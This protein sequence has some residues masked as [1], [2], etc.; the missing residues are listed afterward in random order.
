MGIE[1]QVR[2][3][4]REE[5]ERVP[6]WA[7]D[8]ATIRR[9][10]R[11]QSHRRAAVGGV[12]AVAA[13]AAVTTQVLDA[14]P[15]VDTTPAVDDREPG[16]LLL[17]RQ[18][19]DK[20]VPPGR[21][22]VE[23][24]GTDI[25]H[26]RVEVD[27]PSGFRTR[28]DANF[29]EDS[30]FALRSEDRHDAGFSVWTVGGVNPNPC[31]GDPLVAF[32]RYPD[33]GPS[34]EDLAR[35][36]SQQPHRVGAAPRP[37]TLGG[38]DGLYLELRFSEGFDPDACATG[39]YEAWAVVDPLTR[40]REERFSY[41][42][43]SVDRIWILDVEGTRVVVNAHHDERLPGDRLAAIDAMVASLEIQSRGQP[44]S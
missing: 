19:T 2:S 4:L 32:Q 7:P 44:G 35:A 5:V 24:A 42:P 9:S 31:G 14:L 26:L 10:A 37:V 21:Y 39:H 8:M 13:F 6:P 11:S 41:G 27:V 3:T 34:V 33:P 17:G 20:E 36:L 28:G 12:V 40:G 23:V 18:G 43:R 1:E 22:V 30:D 16:T 15:R 29:R 38:Y 25:E